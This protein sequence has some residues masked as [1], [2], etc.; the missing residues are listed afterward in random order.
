MSESRPI[1][2]PAR[3]FAKKPLP[4]KTVTEFKGLRLHGA[5][6]PAVQFRKVPSH[7]FSHP[8]AS[9]GLLYLG[10]DL[11]TCLWEAFGDVI[12]NPGSAISLSVWMTRQVSQIHTTAKLRLCDLTDLKTRTSLKVDLSA[13]KHT[14][15]NIPQA[16][17]LA[18]MNH[19]DAVDGFHYASRFTGKRCT[20]LFGDTRISSLLKSKPVGALT[21]MDGSGIFLEENEI[22]LV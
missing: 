13:L 8:D 18:I 1:R 6:R 2:L 15:L 4:V 22:A 10:D 12:L 3:D 11:E 5:T 7:R 9:S 20:V 14:E 17:G 19:P 21:D 16:W